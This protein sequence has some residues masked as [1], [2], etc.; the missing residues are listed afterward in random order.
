MRRALPLV[1]AAAMLAL[2][3]AL[4]T[5]E[6]DTA[7]PPGVAARG[8]DYFITGMVATET[9][10]DGRLH[11]RMEATELTHFSHDDRAVVER[12]HLAIYEAPAPWHA[13]AARGQ[14]ER[15]G[16]RVFLD[17]GVRLTRELEQTEEIVTETLQVFPEL[18][19]AETDDPIT[20]RSGN[21]LIEAVGMEISLADQHLLLKSEVR[22]TYAP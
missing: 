8:P 12:P 17:G 11:Q 10:L 22:G 6:P 3:T 13:Y 4:L 14:L 1:L 2:A 15:G 7:P 19:F 16:E 21:R 9:G 20:Y 18:R 5:R